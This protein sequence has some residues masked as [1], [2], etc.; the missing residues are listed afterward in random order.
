M[1]KRRRRAAAVGRAHTS[2]LSVAAV[3]R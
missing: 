3:E 2:G 1:V